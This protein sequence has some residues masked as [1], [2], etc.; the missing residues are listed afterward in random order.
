MAASAASLNTKPSQTHRLESFKFIG[1]TQSEKKTTVQKRLTIHSPNK[2]QT[3]N[4]QYPTFPTKIST[5]PPP[6]TQSTNP[7]N[8]ST[9][10]TF[11]NHTIL[12]K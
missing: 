5:L 3:R 7:N 8:P 1:E 2:Y 10:S 9:Q 4:K 12:N 11:P 6:T